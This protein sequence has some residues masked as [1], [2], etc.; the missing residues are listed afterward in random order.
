MLSS[1]LQGA[2][3]PFHLLSKPSVF[4]QMHSRML[5]FGTNEFNENRVTVVSTVWSDDAFKSSWF[6]TQFLVR[7][8]KTDLHKNMDAW[9]L[10]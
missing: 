3:Q 8:R 5:K 1:R 7:K 2:L 9:V 10:Q 6:G 4:I